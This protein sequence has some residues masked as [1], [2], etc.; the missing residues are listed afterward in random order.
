MKPTFFP[1]P[2]DFRKWLSQ[3]HEV[4]QELWVGYYKK[5]TKVPSVTWPE[6]VDEAL[7][8]GW[9]D[10]LRKSIDEKS[11]MIRFTPR[12]AT[13]HWSNVNI[14]R[15]AEL[16]KLK[17]MQPAGIAAFKKLKKENSGKAS[18]EQKSVTLDKN[19]ITQ[20]Q[21]SEK[22]WAFFDALAPSYKKATIWYVMS[23]K[24][25]TTRQRRLQIL[26]ESSEQGLKIPML[27]K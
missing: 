20:I 12:K 16:T 13:S 6:S 15:V 14:K 24:Q 22:A 10:G 3:H 18:F 1:T 7:C 23:A 27:R 11:Y 26:I 5:A 21:T 17:Q 4:E 9:I 19:Y 8:Y 25:E 2:S